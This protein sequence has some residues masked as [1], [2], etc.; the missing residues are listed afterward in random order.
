M[1]GDIV[2]STLHILI[3]A[4]FMKEMRSTSVKYEK[5]LEKRRL[6]REN[7]PFKLLPQQFFF[8]TPIL[9]PKSFKQFSFSYVKRKRQINQRKRIELEDSFF[10]K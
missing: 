8:Y 1:D 5:Y 4:V 6:M 3:W 9:Q 10:F 7:S 2:H